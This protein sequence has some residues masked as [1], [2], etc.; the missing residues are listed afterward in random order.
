MKWG[1]NME[2]QRATIKDWII[3]DKK[4]GQVLIGH[5]VDHP[6]FCQ[7]QTITTSYLVNIDIENKIAET[8]NTIYILV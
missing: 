8:L 4:N 5:I 2:K 7:G 1:Y 3:S 6:R